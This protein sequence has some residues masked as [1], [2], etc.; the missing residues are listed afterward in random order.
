MPGWRLR[1]R[2]VIQQTIAD[3]PH[4][5]PDKHGG[6]LEPILKALFD[7]YPFGER[8]YTP[9]KEWLDER[10]KAIDA[11]ATEPI[12]RICKVCGAKPMRACR[13]VETGKPLA[14]MHCQ[15]EGKAGASGPLFD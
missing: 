10:A 4:L 14:V 6:N 7:A 5:L 11:L 2:K 13:D 8:R 15:R 9:Y 12:Q 1:A 3:N